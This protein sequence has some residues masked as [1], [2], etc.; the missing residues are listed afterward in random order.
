MGS[1]WLRDLP[2]ALGGLPNL[3]TYSGW[4]NRAR[5]S[6]G[7]D[8][9]LGIVLHHTAS[10]TTPENDMY[11]IWKS[12]ADRPIGAIYIG[13]DGR[14]V[15]GAAGATNCQG[16]GGPLTTSKGTVPLDQGNRYMIAIEA[17]NTGVGEPW[18][19]IQQQAYVNTVRALCAYYGFDPNRDVFGHFDYCAPS[20]PGRKIDPAG[21]S[22]FGAVN[23]S[24]T[25]DINMFRSAVVGSVPPPEPEPE[26]EPTPPPQQGDWMAQLPTIKK[27]DRGDYVERM[28]HLLAAAGFM[29]PANTANYDGVWGS[30]TENAKVAFDNAHGLTPS[31]PTDCGPKSWESLMTGKKW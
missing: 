25:W 16:K 20:C 17:G 4:E 12:A 15:I 6:G 21:P 7:Y 26:P 1:H 9:V 13:R 31:P 28:Q 2:T 10:N 24:G 8:A 3:S 30:G 19:E 18:A 14:I 29:N 11:Y 23:T 27:G 22:L 5:S